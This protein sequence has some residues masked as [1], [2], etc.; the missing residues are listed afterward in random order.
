MLDLSHLILLLGLGAVLGL[1]G[2]LFGIG[3]GILA[4]PVLVAWFGSGQSQAQGTALVMMV[5]NLMLA[6]WRYLAHNPVPWRQ[7]GAVA[8]CG[9]AATVLT[10]QVALGLNQGVLRALFALF[11]IALAG[12]ALLRPQQAGKT[13]PPLIPSRRWLPLVGLAGGASMGLLGV[14]GG[15]VATPLMTG[16]FGLGQRAAQCLALGLVAVASVAA[17]TSYAQQGQV[18]WMLGLALAAGGLPTVPLGVTLAHRWPERRLAQAFAALSGL[19]GLWLLARAW[20]I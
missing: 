6:W 4:V 17:L 1:G 16:L 7:A 14:G 15:L 2:G 18:D 8:L 10:A 9:L 5:P 13:R 3:G 20:G 11:L 12:K 19:T